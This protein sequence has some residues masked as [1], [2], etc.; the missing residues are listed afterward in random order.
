MSAA[1]FPPAA[2]RDLVGAGRCVH[3]EGGRTRVVRC[4]LAVSRGRR[5]GAVEV[6]VRRGN[7]KTEPMTVV[8]S[9]SKFCPV[10][11]VDPLVKLVFPSQI[12]F[13]NPPV[14]ARTVFV[15]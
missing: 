2:Q 12:Q 9:V 4:R 5:A 13:R 15:L 6:S 14:E 8:S 10:R 3:R 11:V 7:P 1:K